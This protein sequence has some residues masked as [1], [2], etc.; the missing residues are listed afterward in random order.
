[1][2][3]LSSNLVNFTLQSISGGTE[4]LGEVVVRIFTD[5]TVYVGRGSHQDVVVASVI[6][7]LSAIN[8]MTQQK[9]LNPQTHL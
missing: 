7:Y 4:A 6:A 9:K 5:D 8:K 1:M 2:V 3:G